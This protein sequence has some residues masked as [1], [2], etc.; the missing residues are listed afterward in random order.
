MLPRPATVC[1]VSLYRLD[2]LVTGVVRVAATNAGRDRSRHIIEQIRR[3]ATGA[4]VMF[5]A[6]FIHQRVIEKKKQKTIYNKHQN[7]IDVQDNQAV[8]CM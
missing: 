1:F 7:T 2:V 3:L 8:T 5:S 6:T 4:S